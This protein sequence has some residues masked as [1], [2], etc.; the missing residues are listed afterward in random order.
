ML[1]AGAVGQTGE[2]P[3]LAIRRERLLDV[4]DVCGQEL[5][6]LAIQGERMLDVGDICGQ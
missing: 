3:G 5:P 4:G 1:D 6:G 2:L